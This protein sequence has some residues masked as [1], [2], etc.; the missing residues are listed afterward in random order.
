MRAV[1][2]QEEKFYQEIDSIRGLRKGTVRIGT[3]VSTSTSW[4][5]QVLAYFQKNYPD[6]VFEIRE[7]GQDEMESGILDG[8]LDLALMSRPERDSI[9]FIPVYDD[10]LLVVFSDQYDLSGYDYVPVSKLAEYPMIM[11]Y[12]SFDR[13]VRRVFSGADITPDVKYYFKDDFAVLSM[14][15]HGLGIAVLPELITE[16]FPGDY[17]TRML[18]P[19]AY[20]TLGVGVRSMQEAGP[21]ARFVIRYIQDNIRN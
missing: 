14:V 11:T 18:D 17:D 4:L 6:I 15:Q 21:L 20:R 7:Q 19:E 1:L 3:F 2:N 16:K 8:S 10:P 13:D 12:Q 9:E 5:P